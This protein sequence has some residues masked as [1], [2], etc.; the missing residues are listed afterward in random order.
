MMAN[1]NYAYGAIFLT[2]T[3]KVLLVKGRETGKWSFPKGHP[4]EGESAFEAAAREVAE[5]VGLRIPH[6]Y[7]SILTLNTGIYYI[8]RTPELSVET[9]D[10]NEVLKVAW[11]PFKNIRF[12][13]INVD[14]NLFF[15]GHLQEG[16]RRCSE[17][18]P[19]RRILPHIV[20]AHHV[21]RKI[22]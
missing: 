15:Q 17:N 16:R 4:E 3:N 7:D 19:Q 2:P 13:R 12:M 1:P 10:E 8:V 18:V 22:A 11:I 20:N 6:D 21:I 9:N 14:V 5:E